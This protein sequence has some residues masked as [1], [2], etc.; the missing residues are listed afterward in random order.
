MLQLPERLE[1]VT[2]YYED[3]VKCADQHTA[4]SVCECMREQWSDFLKPGHRVQ[5]Q[6][7][8]KDEFVDSVIEKPCFVSK[9]SFDCQ[10]FM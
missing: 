9:I 6:V 2:K 3:F 7:K 10:Y 8:I 5:V 4:D 1:G